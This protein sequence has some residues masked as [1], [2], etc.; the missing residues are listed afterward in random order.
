VS[1]QIVPTVLEE[2]VRGS[3][4]AKAQAAMKAMLGMSKLD[5][6]EL[7]RAYDEG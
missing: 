3:D 7:Q 5:I 2:L 4:P 1:W 6:A